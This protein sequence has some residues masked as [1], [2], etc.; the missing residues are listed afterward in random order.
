M[1]SRLVEYYHKTPYNK[2]KMLGLLLLF[3]PGLMFVV[4]FIGESRLVPIFEHQ[5]RAFF[6]GDLSLPIILLALFSLHRRTYQRKGWWGYF[7][8]FFALVF[9]TMIP[10]ALFFRYL[11]SAHYPNIAMYSPTKI[12]HD[13]IGYYLYPAI[14]IVVGFPQLVDCIFKKDRSSMVNW[15]V[16][17]LGLA[18]Y[19]VC[20][21]IDMAH[22]ATEADVIARHPVNWVPI[23]K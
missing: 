20:T 11:D 19:F 5:S 23:W 4:G 18:F 14:L 15:I 10:I 12:V 2:L 9:L 6:P 16:F 3:W 17:F 22:P 21:F 7:P 8:A 1:F 13:V